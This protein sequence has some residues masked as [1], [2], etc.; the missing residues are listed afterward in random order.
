MPPIYSVYFLRTMANF[1]HDL[2]V[3]LPPSQPQA[4]KC[5]YV[6]KNL[7]VSIVLGNCALYL[8]KLI[9][10]CVILLCHLCIYCATDRYC[11]TLYVFSSYLY[12]LYVL[13]CLPRERVVAPL[14]L[15]GGLSCAPV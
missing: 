12:L 15:P 13:G 6:Y 11:A 1:S 9:I 4:Q 14:T 8:L 7:A 2:P 5:L 10:N 3:F